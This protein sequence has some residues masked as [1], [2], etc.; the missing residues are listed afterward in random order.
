MYT[1]ETKN[2]SES[3]YETKKFQIVDYTK[4]NIQRKEVDNTKI[5][6]QTKDTK[7]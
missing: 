3:K 6:N 1:I 2:T 7:V 4:R 5:R